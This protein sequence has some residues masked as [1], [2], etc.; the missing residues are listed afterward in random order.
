M[1]KFGAAE[2]PIFISIS[3][4]Q[5]ESAQTIRTV[6][7]W[8]PIALTKCY[9]YEAMTPY[10]D[11]ELGLRV[12]RNPAHPAI[13]FMILNLLNLRDFTQATNR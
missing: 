7:W 5:C 12:N 13:P 10:I 11:A 2:D 6:D 4:P 1:T 9:P 8:E 3:T